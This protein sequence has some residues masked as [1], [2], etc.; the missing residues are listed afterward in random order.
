M[1]QE[2]LAAMRQRFGLPERSTQQWIEALRRHDQEA[3]HQLLTIVYHTCKQNL[4][5][6]RCSEDDISDVAQNTILAIFDRIHHN[7]TDNIRIF[8][9]FAIGVAHFKSIDVQRQ[10]QQDRATQRIDD[11][12]TES[13]PELTSTP[14]IVSA[15]TAN[16]DDLLWSL[17][18]TC[19]Q[20][21]TPDN[22]QIALWYVEGYGPDE[23]AVRLAPPLTPGAIARRWV[24]IRQRINRAL[25]RC[26][27]RL[28]A[29]DYV[30][31]YLYLDRSR[32]GFRTRPKPGPQAPAAA[33]AAPTSRAKSL[34]WILVQLRALKSALDHGTEPSLPDHGSLLI[35]IPWTTL[36]WPDAWG[37]EDL[38][39]R[40]Q[41]ILS[42]LSGCVSASSPSHQGA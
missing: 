26:A 12:D 14:Q 41:G 39:R 3:I 31:F 21:L 19:I 9:H 27:A 22:R 5:T 40:L 15:D 25:D 23:I 13:S 37:L 7:K 16:L 18:N 17:L 8:E 29:F 6:W 30:M 33:Q 1:S 2:R 42:Q 4:Q 34:H 36:A 11:V 35:A 10:I 28:G 24:S 20:Q 32:R 38:T